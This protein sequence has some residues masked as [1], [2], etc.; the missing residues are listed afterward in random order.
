MKATH[1]GVLFNGVTFVSEDRFGAVREAALLLRKRGSAN[2]LRRRGNF[3]ITAS[4]GDT[5]FF[6]YD[7][8]GF[9]VFVNWVERLLPRGHVG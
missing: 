5:L 7:F 1:A 9:D 2:S 8:V 3:D 4:R 6:G